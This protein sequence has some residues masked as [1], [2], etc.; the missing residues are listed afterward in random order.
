[1][2][3]SPIDKKAVHC[4]GTLPRFAQLL[5]VAIAAVAWVVAFIPTN[6]AFTRL[7]G[8]AVF[9]AAIAL[10]I[11][12]GTVRTGRGFG[13]ASTTGSDATTK[14]DPRTAQTPAQYDNIDWLSPPPWSCRPALRGTFNPDDGLDSM[15]SPLRL[16]EDPM[17]TWAI[18]GRDSVWD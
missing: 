7:L 6:D 10:A 1:M 2:S 16:P 4:N 3:M 5:F 12:I 18:P 9:M 17:S 13:S 8:A 14:E 15:V 11:V